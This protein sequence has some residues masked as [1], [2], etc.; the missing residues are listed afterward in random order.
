MA[1]MQGIVLTMNGNIIQGA[2]LNNGI[3][4]ANVTLLP[5]LNSFSISATNLCGNDSKTST[6][7]FNNCTSP[8][9]NITSPTNTGLTVTSNTFNLSATVQNI[10][11]I[12]EVSISLNGAP[13]NNANLT[14]GQITASVN[15]VPGVNNFYVNTTNSCGND[16]K[17]FTVNYDNCKTPIIQINAPTTNNTSVLNSNYTFNASVQNIAASEGIVMTLN[18]TVV[19]GINF[20]NGQI[21][22][23]VI[24]SPGINTFTITATNGCGTDSETKTLTFNNCT[25]PVVSITN[26]VSGSANVINSN[27]NFTGSVQ[28]MNSSE[29]VVLT[30]NGNPISN[31]NFSN[32]QVNANVTLNPGVNT[33]SLSATNACGNDN[34]TL[35]ITFDNCVAP[36]VNFTTDPS[37]GSVTSATSLLFSAEIINYSP[38]TVIVVKANGNVVNSYNN[39]NGI[40]SKNVNLPIGTV[41]IE[42]TATNNC[43]T[44]TKTYTITRCDRATITIQNPILEASTTTNSSESIIFNITNASSSEISITQN[45]NVLS[46]FGLIGTLYQGQVNLING[47][48]TFN[49]SVNTSCSQVT[50]TITIDYVAPTN[51]INNTDGG[52]NNNSN[53]SGGSNDGH[54]NNG[55]GNN[56]DG[57]DS[58]NPG[59]G[60]GGPNG[61][62]DTN[63]GVDDENGTQN[64]GSNGPQNSNNG[65]PTNGNGGN[66]NGNNSQNG[67]GNKNANYGNGNQ[68]ITKPSTNVTKP[69]PTSKPENTNNGGS[70]PTVNKTV[71]TNT[72]PANT[73]K[74]E[75]SNGNSEK[76]NNQKTEPSKQGTEIKTEPQK[77]G[78]KTK[79][80][81][82]GK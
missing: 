35:A 23:N 40:I 10:S 52:T 76:G 58:S 80:I 2:T 54:D 41:S 33:F 7:N 29:G 49:L 31:L 48:N 67:N 8:I 9:L 77:P 53:G 47:L 45:G 66:S 37:T 79:G 6:I 55:H 62:T 75:N 43:G 3:V 50:K 44:D 36:I 73:A 14:N 42:I 46:G 4:S 21:S 68:N 25:A 34:A 63:G 30:L 69:N 51:P 27:F 60:S 70:K 11:T 16:T 61:Q 38:S 1:S 26:P 78:N 57:I 82:G 17:S 22:A 15:L 81:G 18:G 74:P 59:Q 13:V 71:K 56:T 12:Q 20:V 72:T 24:L 32:G 65:T 39:N 19:S 5:G 28:N 64:S